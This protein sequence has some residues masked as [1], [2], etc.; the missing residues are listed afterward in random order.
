MSILHVSFNALL[1]HGRGG[2]QQLPVIV[3]DR[4]NPLGGKVVDG[5]ML[6]E[7]LPVLCWI[8]QRPVLPRDD[9]WGAREAL[10]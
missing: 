9:H 1:C 10:Q 5:P 6:E 4:P 8:H 3:L 7:N 2:K